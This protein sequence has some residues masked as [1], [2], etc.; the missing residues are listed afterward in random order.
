[1]DIGKNESSGGKVVAK[2]DARAA[3]A[4]PAQT[5]RARVVLASAV[6][7]ALEWYDFFIYGTLRYGG[8]PGLQ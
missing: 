1:M 5:G 6:G 3:M 7:S 2:V 4:A 8:R